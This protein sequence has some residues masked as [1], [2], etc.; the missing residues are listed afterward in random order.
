MALPR[1]PFRLYSV[2]PNTYTILHQINVNKEPYSIWFWELNSQPIG[3]VFLPKTTRPGQGQPECTLNVLYSI[4]PNICSVVP[5]ALAMIYSSDLQ[6]VVL[7][8]LIKFCR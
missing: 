5:C 1:P 3:T 7:T 6:L 8:P 4:G 2:S